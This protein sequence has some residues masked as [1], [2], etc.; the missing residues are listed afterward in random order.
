MNSKK[1][2]QQG[3]KPES[4]STSDVGEQFEDIVKT[5]K[6][7]KFNYGILVLLAVLVFLSLYFQYK[8]ERSRLEG[9]NADEE[10]AGNP[11]DLLG[12]DYGADLKTIKKA[13]K[14]LAIVW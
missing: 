2:K 1:S 3:K 11:Y 14:Q 10:N 7:N 8:Y 9:Y 6:N 4:G 5:V 12:V 13:Y